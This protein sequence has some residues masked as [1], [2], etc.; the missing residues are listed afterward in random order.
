M[1]FVPPYTA[2][3]TARCTTARLAECRSHVSEDAFNRAQI[4]A[5]SS[6]IVGGNPAQRPPAFVI[7][8]AE[9]RVS[10][11]W[12]QL[13][14]QNLLIEEVFMFTGCPIICVLHNRPD[15]VCVALIKLSECAEHDQDI[16]TLPPFCR[17]PDACILF[18]P[19]LQFV[20]RLLQ[21]SC[22]AITQENW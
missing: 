1:C 16:G 9:L 20:I 3:T 10:G 22:R 14:S 15:V 11:A 12:S 18:I 4:L 13:K 7:I 8:E 21:I 19:F 2:T 6:E 17:Q 5:V